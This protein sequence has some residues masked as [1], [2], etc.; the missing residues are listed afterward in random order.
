[1]ES[2]L[3]F[4]SNDSRWCL[5]MFFCFFFRPAAKNPK[6]LSSWACYY[7]TWALKWKKKRLL[8]S[9]WFF[10]KLC[11]LRVCGYMA[12]GVPVS[13]SPCNSWRSLTFYDTTVFAH[14]ITWV[15]QH[16]D[17]GRGLGHA[18]GIQRRAH[19]WQLH[20][21][22]SS[23]WQQ[24]LQTLSVTWWRERSAAWEP[25]NWRD[26]VPLLSPYLSSQP[27]GWGTPAG[28]G[29]GWRGCAAGWVGHRQHS[30]YCR[31]WRGVWHHLLILT[32]PVG[33]GGYKGKDDDTAAREVK[34][35]KTIWV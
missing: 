20:V 11:V 29:F 1:M 34:Q 16:P 21:D 8:S 26:S 3:F 35:H 24:Q 28:R 27:R 25:G 2:F 22:L 5:Q 4:D 10:K 7:I 14:Y 17:T 33:G 13:F 18:G 32:P 30:R 31:S 9:Q 23:V 19:H 6:M 12:L 15:Q